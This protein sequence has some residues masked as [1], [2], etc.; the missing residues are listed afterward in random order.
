MCCSRRA[1]LLR[2]F[3][4]SAEAEGNRIVEIKEETAITM[5]SSKSAAL[6]KRGA[7]ADWGCSK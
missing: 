6:S 1:N 5:L 2:T 3:P 7:A 4:K